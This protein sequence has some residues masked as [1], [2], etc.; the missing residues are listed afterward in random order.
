M[1]QYV[2]YDV[3]AHAAY[4]EMVAHRQRI[5]FFGG[6]D[7]YGQSAAAYGAYP[8]AVGYPSVGMPGSSAFA[9]SAQAHAAATVSGYAS[10]DNAMYCP[11]V[12]C[13]TITP[14]HLHTATPQGAEKAVAVP[15]KGNIRSNSAAEAAT[16]RANTYA[17]AT[18]GAAENASAEVAKVTAAADAADT[19][20]AIL[21]AGR[22]APKNGPSAR[23]EIIAGTA[24]AAASAKAFH[25]TD[26]ATSKLATAALLLR[27]SIEKRQEQGH[28]HPRAAA[29]AAVAAADDDDAAAAAAAAAVAVPHAATYHVSTSAAGAASSVGTAMVARTATPNPNPAAEMAVAAPATVAVAAVTTSVTDESSSSKL[30]M[31]APNASLLPAVDPMHASSAHATTTE[32]GDK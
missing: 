20:T 15:L 25:P 26:A 17:D 12:G 21:K 32:N 27:G 29:A 2:R 22:N 11:S 5:A 14:C 3:A 18:T 10:A 28:Y 30:P 6:L 4:S 16:A 1:G 24:R 19:E 9:A 23:D 13:T 7:P 8:Y 31:Y